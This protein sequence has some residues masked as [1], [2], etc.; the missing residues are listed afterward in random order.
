MVKALKIWMSCMKVL[1]FEFWVS[2]PD[3]TGELLDGEGLE[4][5]DEPCEGLGLQ[6]S[7]LDATGEPLDGEGSED[8]DELY[9]GLGV[10]VSSPDAT[11]EL[12]ELDGEGFDDL[13][14]YEW[15][16]C[17]VILLELWQKVEFEWFRW[18]CTVR[19][20]P[21]RRAFVRSERTTLGFD[22]FDDNPW[23][24]A[25]ER[26]YEKLVVDVM[27]CW[28]KWGSEWWSTEINVWV[29]F[30]SIQPL[31]M[32]NISFL[33]NLMVF[34]WA[35]GNNRHTIIHEWKQSKFVMDLLQYPNVT[36]LV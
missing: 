21:W 6:V 23:L 15:L 18:F 7:S 17:K 13:E 25:L 26:R 32:I 34:S 22:D 33:L 3:A 36:Y 27:L 28:S 8:L 12:L 30:T 2:P 1:G 31:L 19:W 29:Q 4:D 35:R 11:G 9:E 14:L 16:G 5:L 20:L 24:S 10:W